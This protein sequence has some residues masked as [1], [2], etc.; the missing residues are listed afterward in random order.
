MASKQKGGKRK[1]I[2]IALI[3][4]VV[5]VVLFMVFLQPRG[6]AYD[7]EIVRT[8]DIATYYSF[9]G[10]IEAGDF[11]I[12]TATEAG[13]IRT[14]HVAEGDSVKKDD[15]ILTTTSGQK[16][17]ATMAGTVTDIYLFKDDAYMAGTNLFRIADYANPKVFI[18]VDEYDVGSLAPGMEVKVY[19]HALE[20]EVTG[21]LTKIKQEATV[22]DTIAYYEAEVAIPQDGTILMGLSTEVTILK[23]SAPMATAISIKSVQFD[24]NNNPFVYCYSRGGEVEEQPVTLGINNGSVVQVIEGVK[25]GET[26]LIPK[27]NG[28]GMMPFNMGR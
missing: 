15:V 9:T 5:V 19:I 12:F 21:T 11:S 20:K 26:I 8:Q 4:I 13:K 2:W 17:K 18:K 24:S 7:E 6:V 22:T 10:N 25:S 27:S 1:W 23:D 16:I 3:M 14:V 28:F